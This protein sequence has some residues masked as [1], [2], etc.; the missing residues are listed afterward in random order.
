MVSIVLPMAELL[1]RRCMPVNGPDPEPFQMAVPAHDRLLV[2]VAKVPAEHVE[3]C[4]T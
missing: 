3:W 4:S 1:G 2:I